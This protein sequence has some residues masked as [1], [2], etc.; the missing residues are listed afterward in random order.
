MPLVPWSQSST[1][2]VEESLSICTFP[3]F[4]YL[5]VSVCAC[6]CARAR[7]CVCVCVCV[8]DTLSLCL[9]SSSLQHRCC[10]RQGGFFIALLRKKAALPAPGWLREQREDVRTP[11]V[12][13]QPDHH[14]F[15]PV[16]KAQERA[17]APSLHNCLDSLGQPLRHYARSDA[18]KRWFGLSAAL[19]AHAFDSIGSARLNI[20]SAG[21][22]THTTHK[23]GHIEDT[24]AGETPVPSVQWQDGDPAVQI[25]VH[26]PMAR[27][28]ADLKLSATAREVTVEYS[29]RGIPPL[30]I[31]MPTII[32]VTQAVHSK[33]HTRRRVLRARLPASRRS[34]Q[35]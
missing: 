4:I 28:A 6:V 31:A 20:V 29:C 11:V 3:Q 25:S 21:V 33:F 15:R 19:A 18:Y 9:G 8:C 24:T 32:D 13:S 16:A 26:L 22:V 30:V 1:S 17:A 27:S 14:R 10:C 7:V 34:A 35:G 5:C 23:G 12:S 2:S